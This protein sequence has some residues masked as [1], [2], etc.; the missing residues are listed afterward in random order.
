MKR[1]TAG[2]VGRLGGCWMRAESCNR[3]IH[4]VDFGRIE[5]GVSELSALAITSLVLRRTDESDFVFCIFNSNFD[6]ATLACNQAC[7]PSDQR[8]A[9]Q[10]PQSAKDSQQLIP[11]CAIIQTSSPPPNNRSSC[12]IPSDS[13]PHQP[14]RRRNRVVRRRYAHRIERSLIRGIMII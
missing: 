7:Q 1:T 8:S 11:L 3:E 4:F 9:A 6:P 13:S 12:I 2:S 14:I 5:L 10:A